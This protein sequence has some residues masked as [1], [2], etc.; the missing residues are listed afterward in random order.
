M[1]LPLYLSVSRHGVYYFRYPLPKS[2]AGATSTVRLSL[3][4]REPRQALRLSERLRYAAQE[5]SRLMTDNG[6][7]LDDF[8]RLLREHFGKMLEGQKQGI[9]D[10]GHLPDVVAASFKTNIERHENREI[11]SLHQQ[12]QLDGMDRY[13]VT[14]LLSSA[15]AATDV[16]DETLRSFVNEYRRAD[17]AYAKAVLEFDSTYED[18]DFRVQSD[19]SNRNVLPTKNTKKLRGI[20]LKKA[21]ELYRDECMLT[22]TWTHRTENEKQ[23]Y[24]QV[25]FELLGED[26]DI[27]TITA[28]D[29]SRVK[30]DLQRY[31]RNRRKHPKTRELSLAD[32]LLVPDIERLRV[33]TLNKYMQTYKGLFGWAAANKHVSENWS[34]P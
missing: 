28:D 31:P 9:R 33:P 6:L 10:E 32:A 19:T 23:E 13:L 24:F 15:G 34:A 1:R 22:G 4:T 14:E 5:L 21:T 17:A 25:L 3:G 12:G 7:S 11:A 29:A 18:Y 26:T 2:L 30:T 20:T 16:P 27:D 8:R